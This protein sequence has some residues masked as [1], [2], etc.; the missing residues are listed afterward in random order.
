MARA[1]ALAPIS[2]L[3]VF[4]VSQF[5]EAFTYFGSL[6]RMGKIVVPLRMPDQA[7]QFVTLKRFVITAADLSSINY[8]TMV[9]CSTKQ[10]RMY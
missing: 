4:D 2:P 10:R 8:R 5:A 6:A 9:Q 3:E 1:G 7:F